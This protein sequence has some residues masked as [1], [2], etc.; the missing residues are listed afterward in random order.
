FK[1]DTHGTGVMNHAFLRYGEYAGA[2]E[3]S[4]KASM[5]CLSSGTATTYALN[6]LEPRGRLFIRN[7]EDMYPGM[8]VGELSKDGADLDVNPTKAKQ[9]T[10]IR[11]AGKDETVRLTPV[12]PWTLEEVIAYVNPDEA[13]EVTPTQVRLRKQILDPIKRKQLSRKRVSD[14][15]DMLD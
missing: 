15:D 3:K 13:I 2:F 5:V 8:V 10:N 11:A 4:R 6:M 9:L 7:G 1:N 14:I 12:K